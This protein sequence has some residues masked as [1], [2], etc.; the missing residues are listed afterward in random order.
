MTGQGDNQKELSLCRF[1]FYACQHEIAGTSNVKWAKRDQF[2]ISCDCNIN[3]T[4]KI[5]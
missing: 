1:C 5:N 3:G 2:P 4:C